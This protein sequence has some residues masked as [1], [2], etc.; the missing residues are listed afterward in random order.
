MKFRI[1]A[2]NWAGYEVQHKYWWWPFW[3]QTGGTNTFPT[4]E[5]AERWA[6]TRGVVKEL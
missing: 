6:K 3:I 2:D 5:M 4:V 1:V